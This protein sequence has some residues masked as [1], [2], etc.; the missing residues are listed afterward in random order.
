MVPVYVAEQLGCE[1]STVNLKIVAIPPP[2]KIGLWIVELEYQVWN[3]TSN[4]EWKRLTQFGSNAMVVDKTGTYT[5]IQAA[6]DSASPGGVII[7]EPGHYFE[8]IYITKPIKLLARGDSSGTLIFG[9][10][11]IESSNVTVDGFQFHALNSLKS[12][13]LVKNTTS[14]SIQ[15]C[16]FYGNKQFKFLSHSNHHRTSALLLQSSENFYLINSFF[17]DCSVGLAIN[18]CTDCIIVGNSFTSCRAAVQIFSSDSVEI[19]RN[20]FVRNL[21][22]LESG[23]IELVDHIL[24]NNVFEK[25]S[26]IIKK[27]KL[28]SRADLEA[29]IGHSLVPKKQL[30]HFKSED[31]AILPEVFIYG[32]CDTE[33]EQVPQFQSP[34]SQSPNPCIYIRGKL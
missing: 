7:V 16:R 18:T 24:D 32:A 3:S 8:D 17:K 15:N 11:V 28:F 14:V 26:A 12:S 33:S 30:S 20:Y 10:L 6:I 21:V 25:N 2:H 19:N 1:F 13:L 22:A 29:V 4:S 5:S 34:H 27:D 23:S 9:Q 31:L